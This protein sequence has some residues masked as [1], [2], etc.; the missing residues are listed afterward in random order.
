VDAR[1]GART[2]G[3][4]G[5]GCVAAARAGLARTAGSDLLGDVCVCRVHSVIGCRLGARLLLKCKAAASDNRL[6]GT[7][8]AELAERFQQSGV[9][10]AG[11]IGSVRL[12]AATKGRRA[13][14]FYGAGPERAA[15]SANCDLR[16]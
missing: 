13:G 7:R 12:A 3:G 1:G 6:A 14:D 5:E 11:Q 8:F 4:A 10:R 9:D 2:G 16:P 15:R